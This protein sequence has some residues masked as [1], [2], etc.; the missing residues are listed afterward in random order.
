ME[1]EEIDGFINTPLPVFWNQT[2][3]GETMDKE[4]WTQI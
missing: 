3:D 1:L 4:E 2:A